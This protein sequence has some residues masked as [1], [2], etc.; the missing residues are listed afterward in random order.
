M[1]SSASGLIQGEY[2]EAYVGRRLKDSWLLGSMQITW[3]KSVVEEIEA[4]WKAW[5]RRWEE[6]QTRTVTVIE[7]SQRRGGLG[8]DMRGE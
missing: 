3:R 2:R 4:M 7:A 5:G 1:L 6:A 8:W